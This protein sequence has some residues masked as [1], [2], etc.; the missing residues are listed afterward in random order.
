MGYQFPDVTNPETLEKRYIG[1]LSKKA[2][3]LMS[4]M[5]D[6][7]PKTR[8]TALEALADPFFDGI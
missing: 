4:R 3:A 6:L 7:N 2:I 1:K 5:L 8:V